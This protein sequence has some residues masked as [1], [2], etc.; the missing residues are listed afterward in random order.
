MREHY[1]KLVLFHNFF[2]NWQL[3]LLKFMI[4]LIL[5]F[6]QKGGERNNNN[7]GDL[8]LDAEIESNA[9]RLARKRA[10]QIYDD[11]DEEMNFDDNDEDIADDD[12]SAEDDTLSK[13]ISSNLFRHHRHFEE[14]EKVDENDE[15]VL[16]SR[17]LVDDDLST[18]EEKRMKREKY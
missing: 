13:G 5:N 2:T 12:I 9:R 14:K 3:F 15:D 10:A 6:F 4:E 16:T 7:N 17:R 18:N 8:K 11:V 1:Q